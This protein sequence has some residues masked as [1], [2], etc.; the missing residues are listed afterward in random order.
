MTRSH[1]A[2]V[3]LHHRTACVTAIG[4]PLQPLAAI[5]T[6][7]RARDPV[8]RGRREERHVFAMSRGVPHRPD[9]IARFA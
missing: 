2:I 5:N 9:G 3:I 6:K 7:N 1:D 4:L 8:A